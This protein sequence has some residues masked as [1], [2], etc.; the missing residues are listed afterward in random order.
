M[1]TGIPTAVAVL[2]LALTT[3]PVRAQPKPFGYL[4]DTA[5]EMKRIEYSHAVVSPEDKAKIARMACDALARL[6]KDP[7]LPA[8]VEAT[9]KIKIDPGAAAA[10][11][12]NLREFDTTFLRTEAEWMR[13]QGL[14]YPAIVD[15]L[16]VALKTRPET[17]IKDVTPETILSNVNRAQSQVCE[18]AQRAVSDRQFAQTKWTYGGIVLIGVDL[19]VAIGIA[20]GTAGAGMPAAGTVV[21]TSVTLGTAAAS[22]AAAGNIP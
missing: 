3:V 15:T 2:A 16:Q 8:A 5:N 6:S 10:L 7:D 20:A 19:A 13:Q 9:R 12:E 14:E 17:R 1:K 11:L 18:F 21:L 22:A 4:V